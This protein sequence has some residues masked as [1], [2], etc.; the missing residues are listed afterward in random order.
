MSF[1]RDEK[2]SQYTTEKGPKTTEKGP[3]TTE[4]DALVFY[5]PKRKRKVGE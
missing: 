5:L 4:K 1:V 2:V 3:K